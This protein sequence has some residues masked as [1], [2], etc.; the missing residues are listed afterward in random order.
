[1]TFYLLRHG[2]TKGNL[3]R[4]YVGRTDEPLLPEAAQAL[5]A[6]YAPPVTRV[7]SSPLLRAVETARI[8]WPGAPLEK[9]DGFS[10]CDFGL[11]EYLRYEDLK[12]DPRYRAWMESGGMT[13]FPGGEA[14]AEFC[15]RVV[16]AFDRVAAEAEKL[17]GDVGV[18]AHG[19]TLMAILEARAH[20]KRDF[21]AWQV[22]NGRGFS[23][24]WQEGVLHTI[25]FP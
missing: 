5:R 14:R 24:K 21:Y 25:P 15:E 10:E 1:M 2:A 22:E 23:A 16:A 4:R 6:A 11:F 13:G 18:V 8:L 20:P 12:D 3:E 7:Y 17:P 19:G 9:V